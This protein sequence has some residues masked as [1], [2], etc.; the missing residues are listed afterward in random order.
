VLAAEIGLRMS[1]FP[2]AD[3]LASWA[4]LAPGNNQSGGSRK[5]APTR[6]GSK[7]LRRALVEAAHAAARM[8]GSYFAARYRH[9]AVRRGRPKAAVAIGHAILVSAYYMLVREEDYHEIDPRQY[10]ERRRARLQ[11]RAVEQ[12]QALGYQVTLNPTTTAA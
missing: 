4:G 9:L 5:N 7:F 10:D 2:S 8:K 6:K 11:K 12:L 3:H 1:Q